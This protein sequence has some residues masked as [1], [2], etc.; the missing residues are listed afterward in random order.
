MA[1][2]LTG[3]KERNTKKG[4][5]RDGLAD[6]V[7][8]RLEKGMG[9]EVSKR[10]IRDV[11]DNLFEVML[12]ALQAGKRVEVRG[13]GSMRPHRSGPRRSFVPTKGKVVKVD[14]RWKVRFDPSKRMKRALMES[15]EG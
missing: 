15:L 5:G 9:R 13:F 4:L 8:L 12:E 6:E 3:F 2:D 1:L 10:Q 14:A 11:V 7:F